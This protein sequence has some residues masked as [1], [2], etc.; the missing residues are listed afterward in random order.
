MGIETP[1]NLIE[2]EKGTEQS[3][4]QEIADFNWEGS[5]ALFYCKL[6]DLV[7]K[8]RKVYLRDRNNWG[9]F[10]FGF[11]LSTLKSILRLVIFF[12]S[13]NIEI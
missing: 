2:E 5:W 9:N 11:S 12:S 7:E 1:I 8:E 4:N 10:W 6:D 3:L 13:T